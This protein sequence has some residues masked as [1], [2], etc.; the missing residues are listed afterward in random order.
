M[1]DERQPPR[2]ETAPGQGAG[3]PDVRDPDRADGGGA[4][5]SGL[6]PTHQSMART[7]PPRRTGPIVAA[8]AITLVLGLAGAWL[9][10]S[11]GPVLGI[12][13]LSV[14]VIFLLAMMTMLRG[15]RR[16]PEL[17]TTH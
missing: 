9:W 2:Y 13:A 4:P 7:A 14:A 11:M 16:S 1:A 17:D 10:V 6:T 3:G 15:Q 8:L 12:I 5:D